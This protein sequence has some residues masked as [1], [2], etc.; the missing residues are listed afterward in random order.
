VVESYPSLNHTACLVS[1]LLLLFCYY[2]Y[3]ELLGEKALLSSFGQSETMR[4]ASLEPIHHA[5]KTHVSRGFTGYHPSCISGLLH[6][7]WSCPTS[8]FVTVL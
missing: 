8:F 6:S 7:G 5:P 4:E 3:S 1:I 2:Y